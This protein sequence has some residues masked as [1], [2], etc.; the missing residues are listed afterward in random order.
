MKKKGIITAGLV[1]ESMIPQSLLA[2]ED[3]GRTEREI[4]EEIKASVEKLKNKSGLR[5]D[6]FAIVVNPEKQELSLV[7][8]GK[9]VK[10]YIVSTVQAGTG[11]EAGS[12]KTPWGTHRI[13]EKIGNGA[14]VGTI[15][16]GRNDTGEMARIVSDQIDLPEDNITTRIMWL[17]GQEAGINKGGKRDSHSRYIYIHGT[18]EEGLLGQ[19]A[20]HGC[21]RMRN[22]DVV[23]LFDQVPPGTLIEIQ[24]KVF[25]KKNVK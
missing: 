11:S 10:T 6:E 22:T 20:S 16:K 4:R 13:K 24:N 23:E 19:P 17:D 9:I 15:F 12:G 25:R 18:P 8:N 5:P 14:K 2:K 21:I 7:L 3:P 1:A